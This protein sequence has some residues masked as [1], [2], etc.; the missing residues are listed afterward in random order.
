MNRPTQ[1][2]GTMIQALR[3]PQVHTSFED[4]EHEQV[5][6]QFNDSQQMDSDKSKSWDYGES[7]PSEEG[8][9]GTSSMDQFYPDLLSSLEFDYD[10]S[11]NIYA[12]P[13]EGH[14]YV[15]PSYIVRKDSED[16]KEMI[17]KYDDPAPWKVNPNKTQENSFT[18][19][20][21]TPSPLSHGSIV[22]NVSLN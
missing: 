10:R 3:T 6:R 5:L 2:Y 19:E 11:E 20:E 18:K 15:T 22:S 7:V 17:R 13:Y 4:W 1:N 14:S 8:D 9:L 21:Y 16:S 12:N